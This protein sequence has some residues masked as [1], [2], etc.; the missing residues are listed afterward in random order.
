MQ[1]T[2]KSLAFKS[3]NIDGSSGIRYFTFIQHRP[4]AALAELMAHAIKR[5]N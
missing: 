5:S 4:Q 3:R 2:N 1:M